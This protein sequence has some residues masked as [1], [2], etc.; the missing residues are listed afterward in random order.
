MRILPPELKVTLYEDGFELPDILDR[1]RISKALS[2]LVD[3][4]ED[5]MVVALH[6]KWGV[7]KT[8]F[9]KRWVGAHKNQNNGMAT[10]VYFDAFAHDYLDDPLAAL[11]SVI[12]DRIP[13]AK[14]KQ[15]DM[16]RTAGFKLLRPI[17]RVGLS[18]STFG[19]TEV[20]SDIGDVVA[21]SVGKEA[22]DAVGSF[23]K[24]Q[25]DRQSAMLEFESALVALTKRPAKTS[26]TNTEDDTEDNLVPLVVVV[27]E[28]DRCR[29]DYALEVL[30]IIKHFFSVPCVH[31]V[32][33]VNLEALENSVS[34]RYGN[35]MNHEAYL[36][37][38]I[39]L[40]LQLPV[41]LGD[42][43]RS[44][45]AS[46]AYL[47]HLVGMMSVPDHL[48]GPLKKQ[49][50]IANRGNHIS[51]RDIN[52]IV[53]SINLASSAIRENS[54][55]LRGWIEVFVTLVVVKIVRPDLYSDF[56]DS[57][58]TK[59]QVVDFLGI[60]EDDLIEKDGENYRESFD[61]EAFWFFWTWLFLS[62]DAE[63]GQQGRQFGDAIARQFDSWGD[64]SESSGVPAQVE[65]DWIDVL[66]FYGST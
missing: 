40:Q 50:R 8:Y 10:T 65:R 7:G 62:G 48:V 51:I 39:S 18:V 20:L 46:L 41:D 25:E 2:K 36:R 61:R 43:H 60:S 22:K 5:P 66:S 12:S 27:D 37:K 34:A 19:A 56:R 64:R 38:F 55:F 47:D 3:E 52:R 44:N 13:K 63:L 42:R 32:L 29:P 16:L 23:W 35:K 53:S 15:F 49:V 21:E 57:T 30:E 1:I 14:R 33:G 28:L 4:V 26:K 45:P 31:F 11:I 58:L 9:L 6:G 24:R 54:N 17:A 59:Q